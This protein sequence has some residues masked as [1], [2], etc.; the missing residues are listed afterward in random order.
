MNQIAIIL[1]DRSII[2]LNCYGELECYE[3]VNTRKV[4]IVA[5]VSEDN[6]IT[7]EY[8]SE[9]R[10][11]LTGLYSREAGEKM[12]KQYLKLKPDSELCALCIIDVDNFYEINNHYGREFGN[13]VLEEVAEKLTA[14]MRPT[15]IV[16]RLGG[17]GIYQIL[18]KFHKQA[19]Q[20][21]L[22]GYRQKHKHFMYCRN[23]K[24]LLFGQVRRA[25]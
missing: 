21:H 25:F 19:C 5:T 10:D 2:Y 17:D 22:C 8:E 3:A 15:D 18:R 7:E 20:Q 14:V 13:S 9:N 24:H 11:K 23:C 16:I 6:E 1:N 4:R 12:I